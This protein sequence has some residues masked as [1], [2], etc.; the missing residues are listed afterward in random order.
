MD[1]WATFD[2]YGTLIDWETGIARGLGGLWPNE[3][4]DRLLADYHAV[5]P[6]IEAGRDLLYREVM[7]RAAAAIAVIEGLQV[8]P[9]R[10]E[11][12]AESLPSW[13]PFADVGP[14]LEALR[15]NGWKLGILSNSDPDLLA[16]SVAA[17]GVHFDLLI[18]AA[19]AGSYKPAAGHWERFYT[20]LRAA[21][22][23]HVHVAAGLF[24]DVE[25]CARMGIDCVWVNREEESSDL[26]RL[27]E[28]PDLQRLPEVLARVGATG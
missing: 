7:R 17:M 19:D 20:T 24:H 18:T 22:A 13:P 21:P 2:C 15:D 28:I 1:R 23:R 6:R 12:L 4:R 14:A 5:E 25:P 3:N 27:A 26:P 10:E 16:S 8:P 11:A 9:G